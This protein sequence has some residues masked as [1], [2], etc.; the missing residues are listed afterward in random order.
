MQSVVA[1]EKSSFR[2][3]RPVFDDKHRGTPEVTDVASD[4]GAAA[5]MTALKQGQDIRLQDK[6]AHCTSE[7]SSTDRR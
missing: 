7:S 1:H 2:L 5:F 4:N 6:Q 3:D